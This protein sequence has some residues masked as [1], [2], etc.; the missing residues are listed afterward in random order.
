MNA[1]TITLYSFLPR[2]RSGKIRWLAHELGLHVE[3]CPVAR[4]A[5]RQPDYLALNPWG[6]IPTMILEGEV[7]VESTAACLILAERFGPEEFTVAPGQPGRHTFLQWVSIFSESLE[8]KTVEYFLS[9]I[10]MLPESTQSL[11]GPTLS[12]KLAT[13]LE[14]MP[15]QGFLVANRFT[16]ADILAAY[17]LRTAVAAGLLPWDAVRGYLAPLRDRPAARRAQFFDSLQVPD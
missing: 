16:V 13:L 3:E 14:Q 10:G 4:G 15:R 7:I 1:A 5:H 17:T 8:A 11:H 12:F 2:D 9:T 6:A